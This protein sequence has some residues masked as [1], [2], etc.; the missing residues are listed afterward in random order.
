MI[1]FLKD[2]FAG[3]GAKIVEAVDELHLSGEEKEKIKIKLTEL[4]QQAA[5]TAATL[6]Q[7][8]ISARADVIKAELAQSDTFTKRARPMVIYAGLLMI[9]LQAI[10]LPVM[11]WIVGKPA[12]DVALP[13]EFWWAWGTVVSVYGAGRSAEKM[14]WG[15]KVT[16]LITGAGR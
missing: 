11:A 3:T 14:G 15:G 12:P 1:S 13:A 16:G 5:Q 7:A 9:F 2:L 8:E 4:N 10:V 6:A